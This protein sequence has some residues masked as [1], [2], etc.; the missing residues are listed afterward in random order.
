MLSASATLRGKRKRDTRLEMNLRSE[1]H[2]AGPSEAAAKV[3]A[4]LGREP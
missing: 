3:V 4:V 1:L 2:R